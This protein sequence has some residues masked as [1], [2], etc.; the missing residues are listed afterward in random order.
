MADIIKLNAP[1]F[2]REH[3]YPQ[4]LRER[5]DAGE[6][7]WSQAF[8][9]LQSHGMKAIAAKKALDGSGTVL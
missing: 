9:W 5:I 1:K 6:I 3:T 7:T 8:N 4:I 2:F